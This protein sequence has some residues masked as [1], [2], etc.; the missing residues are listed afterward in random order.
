MHNSVLL[1]ML[2][3]DTRHNMH[4]QNETISA[5]QRRHLSAIVKKFFLQ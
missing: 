5:L 3:L 2:Q 1:S 4:D